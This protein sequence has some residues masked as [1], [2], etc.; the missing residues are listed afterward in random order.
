MSTVAISQ[1]E[2]KF[3]SD[4]RTALHSAIAFPITPF[5]TED[6][7][8]LDAVRVNASFL[9]T[10]RVGAIVAPSG[11]GEIFALTPEESLD[12][13]R[14]TVEVA[15]DKPV[16]A[17]AGF[18][19]TLGA[20]MAGEAETAGAAAIMV[21]APY[22]AKPSA[23]G[24]IE[25]YKR[26]ANGISLPVIPY[27]RDAALFTPAILERLCNELPQIIAFKDG[28]ADVRLFTQL[29]DHVNHACG[30]DRLVWLGGSGDDL[31]G[32][33]FAAGAVGYTSS[34]ACFWPEA[35]MEIYDLA[36]AGDFVGLRA[37][38]DKVVRPIYQMRQ[39]KP[40]Y[41]VSV[42]KAA[43]EHLGY[44]AGPSRAPLQNLNDAE[45][46]EL[47]GILDEL[48]VPTREDRGL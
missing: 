10:S 11:T 8:D 44:V 20:R 6:R 32:P 27:A 31:V 1:Q 17:P 3:M 43:M 4:I 14:A 2:Q 36:A 15:G 13:V 46:T 29:R 21:V 38:H 34:L 42:M 5:D 39:L 28:R 40:G 26:I 23:D 19:P 48:G 47:A 35:S 18:G 9:A 16:I 41:E 30:T 45:R 12:I 7:V 25:Y 37:Y 24:L 33:Y 22:Y